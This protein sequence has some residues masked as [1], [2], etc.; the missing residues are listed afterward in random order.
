MRERRTGTMIK[1]EPLEGIRYADI[2][3]ALPLLGAGMLLLAVWRRSWASLP[4]ALLG[5]GL[6]YRA[7]RERMNGDERWK[8][9]ERGTPNL[10]SIP[11]GQGI[12]VEKVVVI[13]R[14]AD[15]LYR[16]WRKLENLPVVM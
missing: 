5:G 6:V 4:L 13:Q 16:F 8:L 2:K 11:R 9:A 7:V 1:S 12:R 14:P 3:R 15:E 10:L